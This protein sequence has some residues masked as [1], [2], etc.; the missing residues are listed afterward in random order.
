MNS[1]IIIETPFVTLWYHP[2]PKIVHHQIHKLVTGAPFRELLLAGTDLLKNKQAQK[3]LSDDR[4]NSGLKKE[5][6]DW[7]ENEWAPLTAKAGWKYWAVVSPEKILGQVA[8]ER[9][10]EKYA[11]LGVAARIFEDPVAAM[12]WLE[13]QK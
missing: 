12:T 1:Q 2:E 10:T 3:W 6:I 7:S 13:K 9:L 8:M 4:G 11:K 5:D